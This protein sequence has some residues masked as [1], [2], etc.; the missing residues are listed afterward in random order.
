MERQKNKKENKKE[1]KKEGFFKKRISTF[2]IGGFLFLFL[3]ITAGLAVFSYQLL[4]N[5]DWFFIKESRIDWLKEPLAKEEYNELFKTGSGR[6][7]FKF[8]ISSARD[9]ILN[10]HPE[11]KEIWIVRNFPDR[12]MLKIYPRVPVAQV[13]ERNFF[14]TDQ[15]GVVLTEEQDFIREGL[16]IITGVGWRIFR[17]VGHREDSSR[18]KSAL[19]LLKAVK[20]SDFMDDHTLAKIDVSDY[21]N[22]S[23]FIEDGLEVKIG[24]T[25]FKERLESLDNTL[26]SMEIDRD[27]IKYIDLRFDDVVLGTK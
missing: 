7:I 26:L 8:N 17:K 25:N 5:S 27:R 21:R 18:M 4:Y 2:I 1:K 12:L 3:L 16:P 6:N 19:K 15:E 20:E 9:E 11:L 22:V 23:F 13:G 24:H 10:A 14:L